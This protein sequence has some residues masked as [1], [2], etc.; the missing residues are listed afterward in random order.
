MISVTI[1]T[2]MKRKTYTHTPDTT[3]KMALDGA[4]A[5]T[6]VDYTANMI[7]LDGA[8]LNPGDLNKTFAELG[9]DGTANH[10]T[11]YLLAVVKAD[12]AA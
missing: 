5:D 8:S 9:Y 3:L 12:N 10:D 11:A 4:K 2:T 6:G 7:T 1:G